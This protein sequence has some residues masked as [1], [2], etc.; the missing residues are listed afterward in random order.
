LLLKLQNAFINKTLTNALQK[1][2]QRFQQVKNY[3]MLFRFFRRF[4][5]L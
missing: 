5:K 4:Q 3:Q 1:I 2:E